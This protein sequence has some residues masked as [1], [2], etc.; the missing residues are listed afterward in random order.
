M[1]NKTEI[2]SIMKKVFAFLLV[3]TLSMMAEAQPSY[4]SPRVLYFKNSQGVV[5][6][7]TIRENYYS[8][9]NTT[10]RVAEFWCF[11]GKWYYFEYEN[12]TEGWYKYRGSE[13]IFPK[14]STDD[15][16]FV[17]A[18][19]SCVVLRRN[20]TDKRFDIATTKAKYLEYDR[21]YQ[22]NR[23]SVGGRVGT[24]SGGSINSNNSY[25]S[26]SGSSTRTISHCKYCGGGGGCSSCKGTG[27]K[28]NPYS[29]H[30]D[31]CPGCGG[32]GRCPI[33]RGTGRI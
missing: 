1:F 31:L 22:A 23:G 7:T 25:Q 10:E 19:Y 5:S 12:Y 9:S 20:G 17:K 13:G 16:L 26:G 21:N 2:F 3:V 6:K 11:D 28:F 14:R 27:V 24:Y 15:Y 30:N 33:C 8:G 32:N 29:G 18:D 4:P